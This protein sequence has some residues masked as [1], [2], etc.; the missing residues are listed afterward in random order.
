G[1][2]NEETAAPDG[3]EYFVMS[4]YFAANRWGTGKGIYDYKRKADELLHNMRHRE[5]KNGP[6]RFGVRTV[7]AE[8]NEEHKMIRFVPSITHGDFTDPSYHLPA[9]Y[10]LW[11]RSGPAEHREFWAQAAEVS[12][13]FFVKTTNPQT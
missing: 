7:S 11:A 10:E 3:E 4:L 5:E 6:T 12:P 1:T 9:S 8:M 2:P 13:E